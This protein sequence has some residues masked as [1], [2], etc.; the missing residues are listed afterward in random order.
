MI[1]KKAIYVAAGIIFGNTNQYSKVRVTSNKTVT[2]YEVYR[3]DLV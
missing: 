3:L 1:I 2:L